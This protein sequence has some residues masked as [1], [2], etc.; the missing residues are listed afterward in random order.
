M[1]FRQVT[2]VFFAAI[3]V[4]GCVSEQE[5]I[6]EPYIVDRE[7]PVYV[8]RPV[9]EEGW[10]GLEVVPGDLSDIVV[11]NGEDR[12]QLR[13]DV[14]NHGERDV[15]LR[16]QVAGIGYAD[17][18]P[19]EFP[20]D[21]VT[22][23]KFED[24]VGNV[25]MGPRDLD[26]G[27]GAN[28]YL[29][30]EVVIHAG[31]SVTFVLRADLHLL[32]GRYRVT[33]GAL[34]GLIEDVVY[35]DNG[36]RVPADQ[37]RNN[38]IIGRVVEMLE[39][40]PA[41]PDGPV[42]LVASF[43]G[44]TGIIT[45]SPYP[46]YLGTVTVT[47]YGGD[48]VGGNVRIIGNLGSFHHFDLV[49]GDAGTAVATGDVFDGTIVDLDLSS[50]TFDEGELRRFQIRGVLRPVDDL[51][52]FFATDIGF[53]I[54]H[55][56]F[57][58]GEGGSGEAFIRTFGDPQVRV[59]RAYPQVMSETLPTTVLGEGATMDLYK[60][61]IWTN[62]GTESISLGGLTYNFATDGFSRPTLSNLRMMRGSTE[63]PRNSYHVVAIGH[64]GD[65]EDGILPWNEFGFM[66]IA[67]MFDTPIDVTGS[68]DIFTLRGDVADTAPGQ[69]MRV[70]FGPRAFSGA[71]GILD[72]GGYIHW[73]SGSGETIAAQIGQ[74]AIYWSDDPAPAYY[75][76]GSWMIAGLDDI[77][78]FVR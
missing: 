27:V 41:S 5:T 57:S 48:A 75:F 1:D 35:V 55:M 30:D 46:Y 71:Q 68:G 59:F 74:D 51:G 39:F 56:G 65:V 67:V 53:L 2:F 25:L 54:D 77:V 26:P 9:P 18:L 24:R 8:D 13:F 44:I 16:Q 47:A 45:P 34:A 31:E 61:H 3:V 4:A 15:R 49:E 64:G 60:A 73:A 32:Y 12:E 70:G 38:Q 7:V 52:P 6:R 42:A 50:I 72:G 43:G 29:A 21:A 76:T 36:E 23:V 14:V 19:I 63:L 58:W 22:D 62:P 66:N 20:F 17:G 33:V 40:P 37:I 69:V 78:T 28:V 11:M 10:R